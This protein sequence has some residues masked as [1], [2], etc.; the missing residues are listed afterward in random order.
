LIAFL[1]EK[2]IVFVSESFEE[3]SACVIAMNALL[4]PLSWPHVSIPLLPQS[5]RYVLESPVPFI[6][7]VPEKIKT[8]TEEYPHI[9]WVSLDKTATVS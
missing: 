9:I 7:G 2:S 3:S 1:L 5:L 8:D 4:R 6:A